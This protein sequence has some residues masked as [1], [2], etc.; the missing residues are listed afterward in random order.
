MIL[1][2]CRHLAGGAPAMI[3]TRRGAGRGWPIAPLPPPAPGSTIKRNFL[4]VI[5]YQF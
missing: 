4:S 3:V 2:S 1:R 5:S